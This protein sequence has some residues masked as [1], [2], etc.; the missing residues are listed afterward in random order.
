[1]NKTK[2]IDAIKK[3][4]SEVDDK[5]FINIDIVRAKAGYKNKTRNQLNPEFKEIIKE[6]VEEGLLEEIEDGKITANLTEKGEN[7]FL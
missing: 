6:L 3:Q 5:S 2:V 1:M 7:S 4:L